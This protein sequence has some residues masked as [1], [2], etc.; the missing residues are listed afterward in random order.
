MVCHTVSLAAIKDKLGWI[1]NITQ[2]HQINLTTKIVFSS[3]P[4]QIN[5]ELETVSQGK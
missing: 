4:S 1:R 2:L 3:S 5:R